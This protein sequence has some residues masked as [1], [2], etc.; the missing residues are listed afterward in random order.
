MAVA[1]KI[2]ISRLPSLRSWITASWFD[3]TLLDS[4]PG[5]SE[6]W[7]TLLSSS[8]LHCHNSHIRG[9]TWSYYWHRDNNPVQT[10]S[11]KLLMNWC[12]LKISFKYCPRSYTIMIDF[13]KSY[14][15]QDH[16]NMSCKIN[17]NWCWCRYFMTD[18][19]A[20]LTIENLC[21]RFWFSWWE[22]SW[23]SELSSNHLQ[24]HF[25]S[26]GFQQFYFCCT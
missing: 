20:I 13:F 10:S 21:F 18:F 9:L 6:Y 17:L 7:P 23:G 4:W 5:M 24:Q 11:I 12:W 14:I 19:D 16:I 26:F 25:N 1:T 22:E 8:R 15:Q 3:Y 2:N